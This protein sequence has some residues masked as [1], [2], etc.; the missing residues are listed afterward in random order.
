[1]GREGAEGGE[2]FPNAEHMD[3][4]L[5]TWIDFC[6][7]MSVHSRF[8]LMPDMSTVASTGS[9]FRRKVVSNRTIEAS[10]N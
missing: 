8:T 10:V 5:S 1:M 2:G 3:G 7:H 6:M 4:M 9:C